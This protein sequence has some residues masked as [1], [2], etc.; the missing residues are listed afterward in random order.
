MQGKVKGSTSQSVYVGIDVSKSWLDV[1]M[2]PINKVFRVANNKKGFKALLKH[3]AGVSTAL[4]VVEATGKYSNGVHR[5]LSEHGIGVAVIN[6]YRSRKFADMLGR[7]AKTDVIDA[8]LLAQFAEMVRPQAREPASK[9]LEELKE[10]MRARDA[11]IADRTALKNRLKTAES[12]RLMSELERQ[13]KACVRHVERLETAIQNVIK[14]DR[15]LTLRFK[16]CQ[17]VPGVG[18]TVAA[19]LI[20]YMPELGK[21]T[22]KQAA[23]LS[24]TAPM[25]WDSGEMRGSRR[26]QGGRAALRRLLYMSAIVAST[27]GPATHLQAT[28]R[29][30]IANGKPAKVALVAVMRK[31]VILANT[32]IAEKR[33]WQLKTA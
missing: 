33:N 4:V 25:N 11:A 14:E 31:L 26:I 3:L 24:G 7:L 23:A 1:A 10:L 19:G 2:R 5:F 18:P 27:R 13:L 21:L 8:N 32:L 16:I 6:P 30:L 29:H 15:D 17:S 12:R 20:A 22:A 9:S 28:Y